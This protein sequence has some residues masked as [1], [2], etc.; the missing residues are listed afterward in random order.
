MMTVLVAA[1]LVVLAA[2]LL[3]L[4]RGYAAWTL[5]GAAALAWWW[6]HAGSAGTGITAPAFTVLAL[7]ALLAAVT[8]IPVLRRQLLSRAALRLMRP[9]LPR[10]GDYKHYLTRPASLIF[11][12]LVQRNAPTG[13]GANNPC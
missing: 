9:M 3:Y 12:S 13:T 4:G 8:G 5:P 1:L 6:I 10:I 11:R 7:F 2:R